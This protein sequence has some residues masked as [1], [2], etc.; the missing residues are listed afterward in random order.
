MPSQ[1]DGDHW[2]LRHRGIV[3]PIRQRYRRQEVV[4]ADDR[5]GLMHW[6][7]LHGLF[8]AHARNRV[9]SQGLEEPAEMLA[10]E[11]MST[12]AQ[13]SHSRNIPR[14]WREVQRPDTPTGRD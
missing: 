5:V 14:A 6:N 11:R 1:T 4:I 10:Q 7:Q 13:H 2:H 3:L 12:D 8:D 9:E